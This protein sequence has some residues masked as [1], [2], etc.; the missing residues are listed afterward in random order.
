MDHEIL[1]DSVKAGVFVPQRNAIAFGFTC[2]KLPEVLGRPRHEIMIE[3]YD[4]AA[5]R[6]GGDRNV[7]EH[8]RVFWVAK[9]VCEK[10]KLS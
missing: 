2:A 1:D 3:L 9:L 8:D 5:D 10:S 6:R 4:D 7:E